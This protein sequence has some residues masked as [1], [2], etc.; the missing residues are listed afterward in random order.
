MKIE[1]LSERINDYKESIKTVANK[2]L[3]WSSTT[4]ELIKVTLNKIEKK[5][6]IGWRVQEL[7]W[8]NINEAINITFQSFP[9]SLL[10]ETNQCPTFQFIP[11]G[12]LIFNQAYSGDIYVFILLPEVESSPLENNRIDLNYYSPQN[13]TEKIII[14]KIDEFLKEMIA[15]E[16]PSI[17]K[18]RM[19]FNSGSNA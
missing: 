2:K 12:A 13:I 14:E 16:V 1:H 15:W 18:Q 11:G 10:K 17:E 9:P 4:K 5:Y 6:D 3:I 7:N 19:G 8:M